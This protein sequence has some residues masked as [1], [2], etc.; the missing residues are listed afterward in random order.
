MLIAAVPSSSVIEDTNTPGWVFP[1]VRQPGLQRS[2]MNFELMSVGIEEV[3]GGAFASVLFPY[4]RLG[5]HALA[6]RG[7]IRVTHTKRDVA[8]ISVG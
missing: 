2:Q 8:I 4:Y 3:G 6:Q 7:V 1:I 5:H